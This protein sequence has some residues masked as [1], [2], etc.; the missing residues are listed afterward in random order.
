MEK[1]TVAIKTFAEITAD[2]MTEIWGNDDY[3]EF[4]IHHDNSQIEYTSSFEDDLPAD[5]IVEITPYDN[6]YVTY[7]DGEKYYVDDY[8]IDDNNTPEEV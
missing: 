1:Y 8:M 3:D 4:I 6:H 7:I 2:H 5:R